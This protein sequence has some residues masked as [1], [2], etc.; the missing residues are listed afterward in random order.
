MRVIRNGVIAALLF[1]VTGETYAA[2]YPTGLRT[3]DSI[4]CHVRDNTCYVQISGDAAGPVE[5][6]SISLR[7]NK[8]NDANG[9][10]VLALLMSAYHS[11][12]KVEFM[13]DGCYQ[14]QNSYPA[15]RYFNVK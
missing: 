1:L 11:K 9:D 2:D 10:A 5:C 6:R 7:W 8:A 4:G 3:I 12:K 15:F 14:Y 13:I